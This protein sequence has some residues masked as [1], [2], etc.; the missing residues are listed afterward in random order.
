[1]KNHQAVC[2]LLN[3]SQKM[4]LIFT[5]TD[6][7]FVLHGGNLHRNL[8]S[9]EFCFRWKDLELLCTSILHVIPW[10]KLLG[11]KINQCAEFLHISYFTESKMLSIFRHTVLCTT[12]KSFQVNH[13]MPILRHHSILAMYL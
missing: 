8:L 12:K 13:D 9:K 11:L 4:G 2:F 6:S 10:I 3:I 5:N 1:M 7:P